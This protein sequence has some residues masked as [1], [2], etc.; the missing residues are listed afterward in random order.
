MP[1]SAIDESFVM[2]FLV[3][4]LIPKQTAA[5]LDVPTARQT[6]TQYSTHSGTE[7]PH[8]THRRIDSAE[9]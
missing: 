5:V 3:Q 2:G 7:H 9:G 1:A 6:L 4:S 8:R